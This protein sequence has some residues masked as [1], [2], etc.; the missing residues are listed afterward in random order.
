MVVRW[1]MVTLALSTWRSRASICKGGDL[2]S[3]H[4]LLECGVFQTSP[5]QCQQGSMHEVVKRVIQLSLKQSGG[6]T[7]CEGMRCIV[8]CASKLRCLND[9]VKEKCVKVKWELDRFYHIPCGQ[10]NC[11]SAYSRSAPAAGTVLLVIAASTAG[12]VSRPGW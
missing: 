8:E 4:C 12:F 9:A 7:K 2:R 5:D 11:N 10:L 3:C 6:P 1:F